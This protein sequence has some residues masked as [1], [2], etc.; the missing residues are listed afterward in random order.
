MADPTPLADPAALEV[1]S[2]EE[3][4]STSSL[5]SS[6]LKYRQEN[7]RTYHGYKDGQYVMP[8]DEQEQD[9]L[10]LQHHLF[11]V[12]LDDKIY[13]SPAGRDGHLYRRARMV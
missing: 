13:L 3:G 11:L 12:T 2:A 5:T 9:R 6:I 4:S 10:D 7:G 1:A 8:N